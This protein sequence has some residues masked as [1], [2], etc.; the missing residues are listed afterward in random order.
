MPIYHTFDSR[1]D[2]QREQRRGDTKQRQHP[3]LGDV[4]AQY[5]LDHDYHQQAEAKRA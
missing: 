2:V 4:P 1:G 5:P 3:R